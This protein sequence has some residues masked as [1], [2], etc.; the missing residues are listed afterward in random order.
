MGYIL[1]AWVYHLSQ[2]PHKPFLGDTFLEIACGLGFPSMI[3]AWLGAARVV[4]TDISEHAIAH[5]KLAA[6]QN[7]SPEER[8]RIEAQTLDIR[9]LREMQMLGLFDTILIGGLDF[10]FMKTDKFG[11]L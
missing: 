9:N 10:A 4:A 2:P 7:L 11:V 8:S 6:V 3:A 5:A 1:A